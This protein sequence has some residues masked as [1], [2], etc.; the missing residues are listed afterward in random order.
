MSYEVFTGKLILKRMC[1]CHK[2]DNRKCVNPN[3]LF[4]GSYS[5]NTNDMFNK[6]RQPDRSGELNGSSKLT[7]AQ[8]DEIRSLFKTGNYMQKQLAV[9]F[10]IDK[11][12]ISCIV[13]NK[14][15]KSRVDN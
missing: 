8:V 4:I 11:S 1:V 7:K 10:N 14:Y 6:N 12:M 13:N 15:W 9:M 5:D 3:H 2:C